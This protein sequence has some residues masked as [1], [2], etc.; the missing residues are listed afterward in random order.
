MDAV[1]LGVLCGSL[2]SGLAGWVILAN[3]VPEKR[4]GFAGADVVG[5]PTRTL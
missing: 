4:T 2:V 3:S 1:K 5:P